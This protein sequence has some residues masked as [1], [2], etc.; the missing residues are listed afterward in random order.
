MR[1]GTGQ[2]GAAC[3]A[4]VQAVGTENNGETNDGERMLRI[5]MVSTQCPCRLRIQYSEE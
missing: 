4:C 5:D 3:V 1:E 2:W